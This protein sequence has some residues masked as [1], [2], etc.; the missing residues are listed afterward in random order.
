MSRLSA[1]NLA[2]HHHLS[3]DLYLHNIYYRRAKA[4]AQDPSELAKANFERGLD[5]ES[6]LFSFLDG[7]GIDL[8]L[9]VPP[10]PV[11]ADTLR[12]NIEADDRDHFFVAGVAFWPPP[13]LNKR[14]LDAGSDPVNFGLAKPD[15]LEI[16]RTPHGI[17]WKVVDAKGSKAVKTSHHVQIY[18]YNL[19][20]S[21]LLP[22]P[23][24]QPAGSA[25]IWLP[26][27]DGFGADS[28][29][30]F[31]DLKSINTSLLA[32]SLDDFLFRRLP[33]ILSLPR[34]KVDWHYN[35]LCRGCPFKSDCE[36]RTIEDGELGAIP[37]MSFAEVKTIRTLLGISRGSSG[38]DSFVTDIEDLHLLL[39]DAAKLEKIRSSFP[40]TLKK[41][42]RILAVQRN[43]LVSPIVEA[44]RTKT[45]Q[46]I[47]RRNYTCPQRED[48]A[49]I[50][51]IIVDPSTSKGN[52]ASFYVSVFSS[53]PS[54]QP[55]SVHGDETSVT[56]T[57]C[58][59][60]RDILALNDIVR[61]VPLT[62][63][64][65]FSAGE[66]AAL[67]AHLI[68]N[69]LISANEDLRLCI[70]ALAQGASLL[71]T[72][73]QPLLL[74]GALLDF[75]AKGRRSKLE[76]QTCLERMGL[77]T[78]GT[79]DEL[80]QRIQD[81]IRRL[82]AEGGRSMSDDDRRTELGQL[83]RVVV[84]RN[85]VST[86]LALP[87]PG[88][89]DL[90]EC[91]FAILP[92]SSIDRKCPS[93]EDI[94]QA[95]KS[96]RD[97]RSRE[98]REAL[99]D[100]L[101]QRNSSLYAV[102]QNMRTRIASSGRRLLVNNA[103]MLTANFMDI[104]KEDNLR[105]LFFMQQFEVLAKLSEL[106]KARI[107]GCPD[108]PLLEYKQTVQ[109]VKGVE[110]FF[111]LISGTL[112]IPTRDKDKSFYDYILTQDETDPDGIP[113]EALFDDL[114]VSGLLFPLNRYTKPKWE[115]Q[116]PIVQR[117]LSVAD[118]RD[119]AVDGQRTK[120]TLQTWGGWSMQLVAG[121]HYRL[122]PRLVDFNITKA[123]STLLEL[124]MRAI[125]N[126]HGADVPFLQL[127]LDPRSFGDDP[128]FAEKGAECVKA[129]NAIQST[130]RAIRG[131]DN[132]ENAAG[133]LVLKPSQHRAVQRIL[134]SRLSVLWGPPG[135]G[136]TYTIAL[137][138]LRLLEVQHRLGDTKRKVIFIT[139]MTHAAIEAILHKL[140]YLRDCYNSIDSL[141]TEWLADFQIEH[142]LKGNDH[143]AP[144]KSRPSVNLLYAGT[145]YQL[146]NFS[147]RH[148]FE[149]D[150]AVID[151]A[152][153][154]ALS[155]AAM[156]LRSLSK[157]GRIVIAGDSEQLAP[158]LTAQYPQLKSRLLFGS[159]LDCLMHLSK[160]PRAR[161]DSEPPA[162]PT[163]SDYSV[164]SSPGTVVQLTENFR[165]NPD[166]G[167][168]VS[169]IY[170]RAF[171]PQKVQAKQLAMELKSVERDVGQDLG[172][173]PQVLRDVQDFLLGLSDVMLRRPQTVLR[174]PPITTNRETVI[175]APDL[176][177]P[178]PISLALL[179]LQTESSRPEGVG[180]EAHVR[181]EAAL[182]AALI[183]S[184]RRCSP[185]ED[186]FVATPHRIQRQA[187]KA[188]LE[189]VRLSELANQML[190]LGLQGSSASRAI[191]GTVTVDTVEKLQGSEA[192]FVICLFSLP[193][194][195]TH[196]L[197]FLLERRRLNV[198]ISR[199]KTLCILVSS[200]TVLRPPVN[201][202]ANEANAKGYTFL[203]AFEDRA[204]SSVITLDVD[205][206]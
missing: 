73:F 135:T 120:I 71:Q 141:P 65:V 185:G 174:P 74:S 50:I 142:V 153:Q 52:I 113:V 190:G 158:I 24:F 56:R 148:S 180:Y 51:S 182:A 118:L 58:S 160:L 112:E 28:E 63:F 145:V 136:K 109:G 98:A 12:A 97:T 134:S 14:F 10:T 43:S 198:A 177:T 130:F 13:E 8:L 122:S 111:Y 17:T 81:E 107:E 9:T 172:V 166:L 34:E 38:T 183:T 150:C 77:P 169:T 23:F 1:T 5:W 129:E 167:E 25:A 72:T 75:M 82:Q 117:K 154:L 156:V 146:Y 170:S 49:V 64:Y 175:K 157:T 101:E 66:Q 173:E 59:L 33:K 29:P 168:F 92:P 11:D 140:S 55:K 84:L 178:T 151:E 195:A 93:D 143:A 90:P 68:D 3:C 86:L 69:A 144:S 39:A 155:S 22:R 61:P 30:S 199:A 147:K 18:F 32:P 85:E 2:V 125:T 80:R 83:P 179:R 121:R 138:L 127:I 41:A 15:L 181:G 70:G 188:A 189:E 37:N 126:E 139:A 19:C 36:T 162:S 7:P 205:V 171:K 76:L 165:L 67:Q 31:D 204:W 203:R 104:C 159:I 200:S 20:L 6:C 164:S 176:L 123:L 88:S 133:A 196:D 53:I 161:R 152:G 110:H 60:I 26:P 128:A 48:I 21:Y 95:Y 197:Q 94:F 99:E 44:A 187:V 119:I 54:F 115:A 57:L 78:S 191:A 149:V 16:T 79:A 193:P 137:A 105:K 45:V 87:L 114:G 206:F 124:D 4:D 116:N 131:L 42:K 62:Q 27:A 91:A 103:R 100:R 108:A 102:L 35:P 202:L 40:S 47:P 106:W 194:C 132:L 186:I 163:L 89:W 192:A 46:V 96:D 184:I 201:V